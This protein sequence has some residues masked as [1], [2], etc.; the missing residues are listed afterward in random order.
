MLLLPRLSFVHSSYHI[1]AI[2]FLRLREL[3]AYHFCLRA[4]YLPVLSVTY[5]VMI[6]FTTNI[7]PLT[8]YYLLYCRRLHEP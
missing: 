7:E 8:P 5:S 1:P 6:F 3:A 4:M 2:L